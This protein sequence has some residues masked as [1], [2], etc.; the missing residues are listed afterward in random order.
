MNFSS[1]K[2]EQIIGYTF[3]DK[4]LLMRAFTHSSYANELHL[5]SNED[6][7][8]LGDSVVGYIMAEE[9]FRKFSD[10]DEGDL[11]KMRSV[12]VSTESF[13]KKTVDLGI[14]EFLLFGVGEKRAEHGGYSRVNANV[15]E[16]LIAAI[17]LD[18]GIDVCRDIVVNR[19]F[20][21]ELEKI[22][23]V[24]AP[25]LDYKS[26]LLEYASKSKL[27][28]VCFE[29]ISRSGADHSPT[30]TYRVKL[31]GVTYPQASGNNIKRAQQE[32]SRLAL[33]EIKK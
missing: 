23:P 30:F 7:E 17:Y 29:R 10:A 28:T 4:E 32:A 31:D 18:G 11:S 16:A 25:M 15:L 1:E 3:S 33:E 5:K 20:K 22:S 9:L 24:I 27:G 2:I 14:G 6:L 26:S 19:I 12:I 21:S 13:A 8:F